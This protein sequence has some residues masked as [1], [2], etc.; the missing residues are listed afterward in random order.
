[1]IDHSGMPLGKQRPRHDPRTLQLADYLDTKPKNLVR[2]EEY[3]SR[4]DS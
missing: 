1:M 2:L 3:M 4:R